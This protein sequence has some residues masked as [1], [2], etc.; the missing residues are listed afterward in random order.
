M[1]NAKINKLIIRYNSII[2]RNLSDKNKIYA[3]N[4]SMFF[5]K[6]NFFIKKK[7]SVRIF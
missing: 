6:K 4:G 1:D 2:N 7:L 5:F 3:R